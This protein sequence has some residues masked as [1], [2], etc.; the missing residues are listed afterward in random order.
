MENGSPRWKAWD[1]PKALQK[2]EAMSRKTSEISC[3]KLCALDDRNWTRGMETELVGHWNTGLCKLTVHETRPDYTTSVYKHLHP[4]RSAVVVRSEEWVC[5]C[6]RAGNAGSYP[7][8]GHE[9]LSFVRVVFC[10]VEDP[11]TGWSLFQRSPTKCDV[12]GCVRA[13]A[14]TV[15]TFWP[16]GGFCARGEEIYI[17]IYIYK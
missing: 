6:L 7:G 3:N 15:R 9:Y 5:A 12:S 11:A 8:R 1:W 16:T 14:S 2:D 17:C 4:D 10:R 13:A